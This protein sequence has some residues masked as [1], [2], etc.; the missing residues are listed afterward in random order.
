MTFEELIKRV[1]DAYENDGII[2]DYQQNIDGRFGD[3]LAEFIVRELKDV[4]DDDASFEANL[5]EALRVMR[6][7]SSELACIVAVMEDIADQAQHSQED[8]H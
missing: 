2:E 1:S 5:A 6:R 4:W 3:T 8:G 7:A